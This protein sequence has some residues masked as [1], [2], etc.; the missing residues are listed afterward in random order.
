MS[1]VRK[2]DGS[3]DYE[4]PNLEETAESVAE[5]RTQPDGVNPLKSWMLKPGHEDWLLVLD[6]FDD[7]QMKIDC[8][9][10]VG[11][12]EVFLSRQE[13]AMLLA[14]LQHLD[15]LLQLWT[16]PTQISFS[17]AFNTPALSLVSKD[18]PLVLNTKI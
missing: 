3:A 14:P 5:V 9:L 8:F 4:R 11:V 17:L 15:F 12:S 2:A 13:I 7:I 1:L 10:Y 16:L 6:N 18:L